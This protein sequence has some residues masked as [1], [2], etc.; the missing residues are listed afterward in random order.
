MFCLRPFLLLGV[1]LL[2][3]AQ[4]PRNR[5][6]RVT[7]HEHGTAAINIAV[8][9]FG[10]V[11]EIEAPAEGM[12]GFEHEAR[13]AAQKQRRDEALNKLR[14]RISEMV[15]FEPLRGCRFT[16]R[17]AE[18]VQ[19]AGE[20]HAEIHA[21]YSVSCSG[22]LDGTDIRFGVTKVFPGVVSVAVQAIGASGQAGATIK[23]DRGAVTIPQ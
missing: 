18:M 12:V 16:V 10:A 22:P 5:T 2:A 19:H 4:A 15:V 21:E 9:T 3:A 20:E 1:S 14:T 11:V 6:K 8:E 17:K 7:S 23:N 13:T